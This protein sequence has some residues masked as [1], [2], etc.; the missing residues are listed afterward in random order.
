MTIIFQQLAPF[1]AV[2]FSKGTVLLDALFGS[3]TR[4]VPSYISTEAPLAKAGLL[5][6]IGTNGAKPGIV[7]ASPSTSDPN[8]LYTWTRDSSLVFKLLIDEYIQGRDKTLLGQITDFIAAE[9]VLQSVSNP[10]GSVGEPKF[11]V[12]ETAFTDAWGRPQRDGPALRATALINF[13]NYLISNGNTSYPADT[14]WPMVQLDLDYVAGTW[15]ETGFDLWEEVNGSSFFTIAVQHRALRE[16]T[17]FAAKQGDSTRASTYTIQAANLLCF[18]QSFWSPSSSALIANINVEDRRSGLDINTLLGSIH[19]FD[20]AAGPDAATFQPGSDR[21]LLNHYTT[22]NSFRG[23]LYSLNSGISASSAVNL[24]RYKED[25]YYNGNPWYIGT[26]AASQQ[27]YHA[28]YQWE[29]AGGIN[30][31]SVSLPFFQQLISSAA[32]GYYAADTSTYTTLYDAVSAYADGFLLLAQQYTPSSGELSEQYDKSTGAQRSAVQLT[33]SFASALTAFDARNNTL[34]SSWGAK[35][36]SIASCPNTVAITFNAYATTVWGENIYIAGSIGALGGWS[37]DSAVPLSSA[38]YPTW[39]TTVYVP[40][41]IT[42][43]Y[44]YIRK[45]NGAVTWESD[46]DRQLVAPTSGAYTE[47]DSWR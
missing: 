13:A 18:L 28:L 3:A 31:T 8:Y 37:P 39:S 41:G 17:T 20:P 19:T 7:I 9:K 46:P 16:G 34:P 38:G 26:F 14:I 12:N 15:N 40:A 35:G 21:A 45:Y 11:N 4:D 47:N 24:G 36:L 2:L 29:A 30:V 25:V 43:Q 44:K 6:N 1:V 10:S 32:V 33:W 23:S 22:V 27:L 42:F 5:A